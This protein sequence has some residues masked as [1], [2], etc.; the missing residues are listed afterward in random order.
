MA[1]TILREHDD[2]VSRRPANFPPILYC[3]CLSKQVI[4]EQ[5]FALLYDAHKSRNPKF[6]YWDYETFH[7]DEKT[8]DECMVEFRFY[9]ED[10]YELVEQMQLP[11]E[12]TPYSGLVVTSIPALCLYLKC[13]SYPCR[14]GDLVR[15]FARPILELSIT[16]DH[17]VEMIYGG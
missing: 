6:P 16:S 13:Y 7:L 5:D 10:I 4:H 3:T 15:H 14:Y 11:D 12:I 17:M 8:E 9:R 1:F 2:D